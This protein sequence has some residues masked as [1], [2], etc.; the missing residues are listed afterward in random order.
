MRVPFQVMGRCSAPLGGG[1]K[2][3]IVAGG[4]LEAIDLSLLFLQGCGEPWDK[5]KVFHLERITISIIAGKFRSNGCNLFSDQAKVLARRGHLILVLEPDRI[6]GSYQLL[7][8]F[9]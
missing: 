8:L 3:S 4:V 6:E 9:L 7:R 5:F 2:P 1:A